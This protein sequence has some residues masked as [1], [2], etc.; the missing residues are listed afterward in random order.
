MDGN[1][2]ND[3]LLTCDSSNEANDNENDSEPNERN[4]SSTKMQEDDDTSIAIEQ[5]AE[6]VHFNK[7]SNDNNC[8]EIEKNTES[9]EMD[10]DKLPTSLKFNRNTMSI[11][12]K[13]S[14]NDNIQQQTINDKCSSCN[15]ESIICSPQFQL[16]GSANEHNLLRDQ[17]DTDIDELFHS[18][19]CSAQM[20]KSIGLDFHVENSNRNPNDR[21]FRDLLGAKRED[22]VRKVVLRNPRGNQPRTYTTDSLY[23]ALMDVKSGESIYR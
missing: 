18:S 8:V 14:N 6:N 20:L 22:S 3:F 1:V 4:V 2:D 10:Y 5:N 19:M 9:I 23:A 13:R 7:K 16:A 12:V 11:F 21:C 17:Q 15:E